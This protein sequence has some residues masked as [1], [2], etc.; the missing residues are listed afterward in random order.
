MKK[1]P[2]RCPYLDHKSCDKVDPNGVLWINCEDCNHYDK[3]IKE[4][5]SFNIELSWLYKLITKL[6]TK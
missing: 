4:T 3:G 6:F 2:Y 5:G 1:I